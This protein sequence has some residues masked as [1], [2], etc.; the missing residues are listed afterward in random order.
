MGGDVAQGVLKVAVPEAVLN[1]TGIWLFLLPWRGAFSRRW[2][3]DL[4]RL[5]VVADDAFQM[6]HFWQPATKAMGHRVMGLLRSLRV[7]LSDGRA[8]SLVAWPS[9]PCRT[10][11]MGFRRHCRGTPCSL[12]GGRAASHHPP[13]FSER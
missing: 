8:I 3:R 6:R 5:L 4:F 1:E 9:H 2:R 12:K 7:V 13:F 11:V 10:M